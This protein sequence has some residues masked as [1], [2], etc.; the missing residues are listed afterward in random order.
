MVI[1]LEFLKYRFLLTFSVVLAHFNEVQ[2]KVVIDVEI[3]KGSKDILHEQSP[4]A[5]QLNNPKLFFH[6]VGA[7]I[8]NFRFY[9]K[10]YYPNADHLPKQRRY[11]RGGNEVSLFGKHILLTVVA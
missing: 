6:T 11:F 2:I 1:F 5:S 3:V 8:Q 9:K 10:V 4:S 7:G